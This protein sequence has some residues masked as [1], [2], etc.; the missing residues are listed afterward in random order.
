M[1]TVLF[2]LILGCK[3]DAKLG[4]VD[5]IIKADGDKMYIEYSPDE[6]WFPAVTFSDTCR[7]YNSHPAMKFMRIYKYDIEDRGNYQ[8][9]RREI[10]INPDDYFRYLIADNV[11]YHA[12][13]EG[14]YYRIDSVLKSDSTVVSKRNLHVIK[15]K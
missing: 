13:L 6:I 8:Y 7:I 5:F 3:T 11:N 1:I 14:G 12:K 4:D 9:A 15:M 10:T 2:T